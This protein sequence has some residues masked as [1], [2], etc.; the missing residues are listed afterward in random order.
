MLQ[1]RHELAQMRRVLMPQRDV[2]GRLAR[3][4]FPAISDEMAYRFRD[5]Y[6]HVVRLADEAILFQDRVTGILEVNLASISNRLNQV[7]K[8]LTVMSTIFLPLTVLSGMWGMNV[9]LPH[10]PGRRG[11]AVLVGGRHHGGDCGGDARRVPPQ[12][13]D[14][15]AMGRFTGCRRTS[16]TRSPPA[17]WS[18]ARRRWSRSWSR[19]R[20]TPARRASTITVEAGGKRLIRVDD[21]GE[22]MEPDDA[23]LSVERHATSKIRHADD[24]ERIATLGFRGEAL[25]SI[26][27]V[28]RFTLRT[29][30]RGA[31]G[32]HRDPDRR[33]RRRPRPSEAGCPVGTS[34]EVARP[35]LQPAGAPEVPQDRRRRDG[36]GHRAS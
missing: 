18:S 3:R 8:V 21:D 29:R 11:G 20:S 32:G 6:D 23:R 19:T 26:A 36:A 22:G 5:V 25:P 13:L 9:P 7:M 2:I 10:F 12:P 35:V 4:E 1:L 15:D 33:R 31:H 34:I 17:R 24:L 30:T 28:S 27:S 14:V 16:P